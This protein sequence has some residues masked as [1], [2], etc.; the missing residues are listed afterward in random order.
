MNYQGA[1]NQRHGREVLF[2]KYHGLGNDFAIFSD[3]EHEYDLE[4]QIVR[5]CERHRGIGA[6]GVIRVSRGSAE[7]SLRYDHF[8][9]DG[10]LATMCGNGLRCLA[11]YAWDTGLV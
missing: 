1:G 8:N 11:Q 9:P 6:D 3:P 4:S 7:N 10:S 5:L 2:R